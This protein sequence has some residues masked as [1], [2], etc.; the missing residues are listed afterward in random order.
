MD[1]GLESEDDVI[2]KSI[3]DM[4]G[5]REF[6]PISPAL[7]ECDVAIQETYDCGG[8]M[9]TGE[10]DKIAEVKSLPVAE[11]PAA[12]GAD[13]VGTVRSSVPPMFLMPPPTL[14]FNIYAPPMTGLLPRTT[15]DT[16]C[17]R[18]IMMVPSHFAGVIQRDY[19][20]DPV[21]DI[22]PIN[23]RISGT[24]STTPWSANL[25]LGPANYVAQPAADAWGRVNGFGPF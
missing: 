17:G 1:S 5:E 20:A 4:E 8:A 18:T 6:A 14:G 12:T 3:R 25:P 15:I 16:Q 11:P 2:P 24:R 7:I 10:D 19:G 23:F 13:E 22:Q 21:V 9:E